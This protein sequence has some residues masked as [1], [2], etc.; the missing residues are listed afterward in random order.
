MSLA[1]IMYGLAFLLEFNYSSLLYLCKCF[2]FGVFVCACVCFERFNVS[3]L[4]LK[5]GACVPE[6]C[7]LIKLT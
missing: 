4:T 6:N 2:H 1:N 7:V 5:K 3:L